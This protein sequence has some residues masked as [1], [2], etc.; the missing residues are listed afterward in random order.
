MLGLKL[1]TDRH[2]PTTSQTRYPLHHAAPQAT[3]VDV[4]DSQHSVI[5][6]THH[7]RSSI[8]NNLC[9]TYVSMCSVKYIPSSQLVLLNG[10]L[11][12]NWTFRLAKTMTVYSSNPCIA[13]MEH[14]TDRTRCTLSVGGRTIW[15]VTLRVKHAFGF[16]CVDREFSC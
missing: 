9:Y 16:K 14:I 12:W 8:T 7:S 15:R 5:T 13:A 4:T 10:I 6:H 11:T 1:T 3:I 2:P